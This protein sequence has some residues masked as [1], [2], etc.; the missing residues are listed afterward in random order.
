MMLIN[1]LQQVHRRHC[2]QAALDTAML[3]CR[4]VTG[5]EIAP[6]Q[7]RMPGEGEVVTSPELAGTEQAAPQAMGQESPRAVAA[8]VPASNAARRDTG[9]GKASQKLPSLVHSHLM[10]VSEQPYSCTDADA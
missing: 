3:G 10:D 2:G 1:T 7:T 5:A 4:M 9:A 8:V 6:M